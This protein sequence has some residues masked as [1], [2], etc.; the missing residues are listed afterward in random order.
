LAVTPVAVI[1]IAMSIKDP[2]IP[3]TPYYIIVANK[4]YINKRR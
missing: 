2:L 3:I 4:G 1:F